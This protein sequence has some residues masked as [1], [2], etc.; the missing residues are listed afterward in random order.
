MNY[1][2]TML[3]DPR[4]NVLLVGYQAA[5]T[6]GRHLQRIGRQGGEL[7]LDDKSVTVAAPVET[8]GGY[9]AH[10]DQAGLLRFVRGM[11]KQP[12]EVRIVHGDHDAKAA[13]QKLL[14]GRSSRAFVD[15]SYP[16]RM[17][18]ATTVLLPRGQT[19]C[20]RGIF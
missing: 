5:G 13:L 12:T 18:S 3:H 10:A 4:H 8:L 14:P 11:R 7:M 17:L 2:K 16:P 15:F 1:L 6:P 19:I 9:S 20:P